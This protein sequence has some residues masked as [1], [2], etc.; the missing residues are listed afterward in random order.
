[1][2]QQ[3]RQP[4]LETL[5]LGSVLDIFARGALPVATTDLVDRVFGPAGQRGALVISG[6]N[7]IVGA[8]KTM[9]LGSRLEPYGVPVVAL[10][11]P[12]GPSGLA[13]QYPGLV[14][15]FGPEQAAR[16]MG[17][18]TQLTYDGTRL[19]PQLAAFKPRFLLEAIPEV[20]ELKKAHYRLFRSS[21]PEIEIRSVTSGFPSREL[22]V[23]ITHPAF[24]HEIN[25]V[26][27]V[28]EGQPS[29]ITQLY[30]SL[31]L[32]PM[33]V[34][35]HWSFVLDVLFTG[36]TQAG[37]RYHEAT[38][39]PF[40]KIDKFLR[41]VV[42]P[43][44]FRAHD[45]IGAKGSNFLTWSCLEHLGQNYG[46]LFT[47]TAT[48]TARKASGQEWYPPAHLRPM[49]N[50][51]LDTAG[52]DDLR[53]WILGP[54]FQMTALMI[55]EKRAQL[56]Q[57][58]AIGEI[59][60]QFTGGLPLLMRQAG[61]ENVIRTVEAYHR[62]HPAAAK[63][64]WHPEVL[65]QLGGAEWQQLYVNAEHDGRVGVI[66]L[67]R[68]SYSHE[69]N[70]EL[71]RA[72]D[73]LKRQKI[74]RV[75]VTGDFHL[76]GQLVGADTTNF[77]PALE[78]PAQG[79]AISRTWSLTARRFHAEFGTSVAFI[80]GKR[81]LGGMLELLEH[82]HYVVALDRCDLGMPEVTLPVV[83]GMEGCH[84]V[85]RKTPP[86]LWPKLL[87]LLLEGKSIKAKDGTG[88][89]VDFAGPMAD[90]I[91]TCWQIAQGETSVTKRPFN[92]RKLEGVTRTLPALPAA[93]PATEVARRA[94]LRTVEAA[95][96]A[97]LAEA[98]EIQA[99]LSAEFMGSPEVRQGRV[100]EAYAKFQA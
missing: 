14:K 41:R 91:K 99:Q 98:L 29:A 47:P 13:K 6:A 40:W 70:A 12:G 93:A 22:G 19:P 28:V 65:D 58:N 25:K 27:E 79:V 44:P 90:A 86:A 37:I 94:I 73:W 8:G 42:G 23:S 74:D 96:G 71:N 88:W 39:M 53:T 81:C 9:Q 87:E 32:V 1:M 84:W 34:G 89:L 60:A 62:L 4:T 52:Q 66:T 7:G 72:I 35:D 61:A 55:H 20:L 10:D 18:V 11:F 95:C 48:M 54:L 33:M 17:N 80:N 78:D 46:G 36:L 76:A 16:I 59:C 75:I 85:F 97:S 45:V 3:L 67:G 24:P 63:S 49:V 26:W 5:G 38:N 56:A 83:P 43:N 100:G 31:G 82:C 51:T 92:E 57:M 50:W 30:W 77:Y 64:P 15:T 21:F 68:E 2:K 69:V